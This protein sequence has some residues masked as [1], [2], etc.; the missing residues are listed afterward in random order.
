MLIKLF[1]LI[2]D[3][4][5]MKKNHFGTKFNLVQQLGYLSGFVTKEKIPCINALSL[6]AVI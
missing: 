1:S 4:K 5:V 2:W 3:R 6:I